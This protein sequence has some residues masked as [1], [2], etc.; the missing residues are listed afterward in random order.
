M[1]AALVSAKLGPGVPLEPA[2]PTGPGTVEAVPAEPA[3]PVGPAGPV[4]PGRPSSPWGP[5]GPVTVR[6][7]G[8]CGPTAPLS[9]LIPFLPACAIM[10]HGDVPGRAVPAANG[11]VATNVEVADVET[12]PPVPII[13][14]AE[15]PEYVHWLSPLM[16]HVP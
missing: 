1:S 2:G 11:P 4:I 7:I 5:C 15:A 8:P 9:P 3:G 13:C 6:P 14:V 16:L 12:V 10:T